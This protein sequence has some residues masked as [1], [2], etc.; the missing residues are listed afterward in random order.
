MSPNDQRRLIRAARDAWRWC[1][2]GQRPPQPG[3][4]PA[5]TGNAVGE[6][7]AAVFFNGVSEVAAASS[8]I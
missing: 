3:K 7:N 5:P 1:L 2:Q 6:R 4:A 8:L